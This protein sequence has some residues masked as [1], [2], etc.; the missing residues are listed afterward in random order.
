[1]RCLELIL[2]VGLRAA[3]DDMLSVQRCARQNDARLVANFL[4]LNARL[5]GRHV[6]QLLVDGLLVVDVVERAQQVQSIDL[7][8]ET[9]G[10][11]KELEQDHRVVVAQ[12]LG[13]SLL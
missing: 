1:M 3:D 13:Q 12:S 2:Q 10:V 11:H 8:G 5:F 4:H 6:G 7:F 9:Q